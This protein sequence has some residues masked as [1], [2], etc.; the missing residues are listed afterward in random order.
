MADHDSASI[1]TLH[2]PQPARAKTPAERS[3]AYR[4]RKRERHAALPT[5]I[6]APVVTLL[7]PEA[8]PSSPRRM[9]C[10]EQ[11]CPAAR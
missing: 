4:A 3:K 6:P 7:L 10:P 8:H 2:Q 11:V 1:V 5:V 9:V